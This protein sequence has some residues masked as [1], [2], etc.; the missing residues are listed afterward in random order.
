MF[1]G[2]AYNPHK[3]N[4]EIEF[5]EDWKSLP[6]GDIISIFGTPTP[7]FCFI[8]KRHFDTDGSFWPCVV[9]E[10]LNEDDDEVAI[11]DDYYTVRLLPYFN[12]TKWEDLELPRIMT[13]YPRASIR[14]FYLPYKSDL[15]LPNAFRHHI[16]LKEGIF[17]E[18]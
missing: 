9:L 8:E 17:P 12:E 11:E 10:R 16:E 7:D 5:G 13:Q 14:H 2:C 18:E 4:W 15:H 3:D 1:T 6:V